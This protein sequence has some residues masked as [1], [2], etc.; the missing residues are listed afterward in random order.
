MRHGHRMACKWP[1]AITRAATWLGRTH[2]RQVLQADPTNAGMPTHLLGI[3]AKDTGQAE[4]AEALVRRA[5]DLNPVAPVFLTTLATFFES[6]D[7]WRMP[8]PAFAGQLSSSPTFSRGSKQPRLRFNGAQDL[9]EAVS[10]LQQA[11]HLRPENPDAYSNLGAALA[12]QGLLD[13]AA[14]SFTHALHLKPD[15]AEAHRQLARS[16]VPS[17]G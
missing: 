3:L 16:R 4:A 10:T 14:A 17:T 13:D 15:H 11:V 1:F 5:I 8:A 6:K 12:H 7:G 2:Y 9:D